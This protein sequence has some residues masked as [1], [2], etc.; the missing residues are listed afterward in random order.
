MTIKDVTD[1]H[2]IVIERYGLN[3]AAKS[4]E[5]INSEIA[6]LEQ[7]ISASHVRLEKLVAARELLGLEPDASPGPISNG[8]ARSRSGKF[9]LG[10][11]VRKQL[12]LGAC[13]RSD[14]FQRLVDSGIVTTVAALATTLTR[15]KY[16]RLV[17]NR[18]GLWRAIGEETFIAPE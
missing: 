1:R 14:L 9:T 18:G 13:N 10:D 11:H 7:I 16:Q 6:A 15:L 8:R 4:V 12:Q 17:N 2:T 3:H 5:A